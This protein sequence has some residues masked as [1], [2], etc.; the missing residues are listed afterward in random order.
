MPR[1]DP[2]FSIARGHRVTYDAVSDA[3]LTCIE[4]GG[5]YS[6]HPPQTPAPCAGT[7]PG[8]GGWVCK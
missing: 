6:H 2:W 1:R 4:V 7:I 5:D 8:I 3:T